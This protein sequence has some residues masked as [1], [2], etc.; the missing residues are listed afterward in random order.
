[1]KKLTILLLLLSAV[2]AWGQ[3][4]NILAGG[5]NDNGSGYKTYVYQVEYMKT[6]Q[7]ALSCSLSYLNDG[8]FPDSH[9]D[10]F[11]FQLWGKLPLAQSI[12][13]KGG[14]GPYLYFDSNSRL[15]GAY[16]N[17]QHGLGGIASLALH[18]QATQEISILLRANWTKTANNIDT[19]ALLLGVGFRTDQPKTKDARL[20][21]RHN[22]ATLFIGRLSSNNNDP[23]NATA[24]GMEY[25]HDFGKYLSGSLLGMDEGDNDLFHR[26]G[27]AAQLWVSNTLFGDELTA[28]FGLGPYLA[29]NKYRDRLL[30]KEG[31]VLAGLVT[32][33]AGY[34]ITPEWA[35][36]FTWNR[37]VTDYNRDTD[38]FL[39]G[40]SFCF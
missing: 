2:P 32:I 35:L 34:R 13:V 11:T 6:I 24:W 9:R 22:A 16:F 1:M 17:N 14:I 21:A 25:R 3:E 23:K 7:G 19:S 31:N 4:L 10:G 39:I 29:E 27:V 20:T 36:R 33:S 18:W 26:R 40:P 38:V 15:A 5:N 37:V 30:G 28:G 8:H 12:S